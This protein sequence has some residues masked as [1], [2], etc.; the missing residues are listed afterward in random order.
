MRILANYGYKNNGDTYSV[1]FET[2]GDVPKEQADNVVDELFTMA[3]RAI[4]RQLNPQVKPS[5]PAP[6]D[7]DEVTIPE[8]ARPDQCQGKNKP[9]IKDPLA[10]ASPKQKSFIARLAKE[11]GQFIE[12]L[13]SLTMAE[14]SQTIDELMAV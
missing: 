9:H 3:K 2:I 10:P 8:P 4:E 7:K 13:N 14:A 12:G 6:K 5:K 11:K 1:T